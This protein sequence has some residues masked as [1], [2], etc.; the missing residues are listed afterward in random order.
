MYACGW[1]YTI[2]VHGKVVTKGHGEG[3]HFFRHFSKEETV[4][5]LKKI[6][7][8]LNKKYNYQAHSDYAM[9]LSQIGKVKEALEILERLNS[10]HPQEYILMANLGTLYELN[11]KNQEAL[12]WIQKAVQKNPTSHHG[13][14]WVHIK[15]LEAKLNIQKDANWLENNH[16]I[17]V[18]RFK[19]KPLTQEDL[20]KLAEL[21]K[22]LGYQLHERIPYTPNPDPIVFQLLMDL[23]ELTMIDD[24]R[25]THVA[26]SFAI[27]FAKDAQEKM[28][29]QTKI[30]E[31][32]A[33]IGKYNKSYLNSTKY[34]NTGN[35]LQIKDYQVINF[36][37]KTVKKQDFIEPVTNVHLIDKY[38]SLVYFI[39]LVAI[40]SGA[41]F[42]VWVMRK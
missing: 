29:V 8:S 4:E 25:S 1:F 27:I 13:S 15:I 32:E 20:K 37:L 12:Q 2:D 6:E 19:V 16:V 40:L 38:P 31:V 11:G 17:D 5:G 23:A 22:H 35:I 21:E 3:L 10:E 42:L 36:F 7:E 34:E 41:A 18:T 33:L 9:L 26:Y 24:L 28:R 14:E 30:T 39:L